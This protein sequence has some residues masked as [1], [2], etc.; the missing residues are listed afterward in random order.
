VLNNIAMGGSQP[1]SATEAR[2]PQIKA[3]YE[4]VARGWFAL[5]AQI[6]WLDLE[7]AHARQDDNKE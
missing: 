5:A 4:E 1:S 3:A 6:D 7:R 2:D